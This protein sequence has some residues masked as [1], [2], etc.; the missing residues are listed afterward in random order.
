MSEAPFA[1]HAVEKER[2]ENDVNCLLG[3]KSRGMVMIILIWNLLASILA[4]A[5]FGK[6]GWAQLFHHLFSCNKKKKVEES[7]LTT[8]KTMLGIMGPEWTVVKSDG[9][10]TII[11]EGGVI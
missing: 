9:I 10:K 2:S 5:D 3:K 1:Q 11:L 6:L 4:V 8:Q 7:V